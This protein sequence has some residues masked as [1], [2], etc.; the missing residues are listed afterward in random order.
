MLE[1]AGGEQEGVELERAKFNR[2]LSTVFSLSSSLKGAS[3]FIIS[4]KPRCGIAWKV[5]DLEPLNSLEALSY[6]VEAPSISNTGYLRCIS[7]TNGLGGIIL[8]IY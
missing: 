1:V 2:P 6:P 5:L 4:R 8:S 3:K 7:K